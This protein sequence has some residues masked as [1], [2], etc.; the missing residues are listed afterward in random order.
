M[1]EVIVQGVFHREL[2]DDGFVRVLMIVSVLVM[3]VL[4]HHV[5]SVS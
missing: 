1:L 5:L 2:E 4:V 3:I